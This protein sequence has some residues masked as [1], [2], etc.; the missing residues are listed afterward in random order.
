MG[1]LAMPYEKD[2]VGIAVLNELWGMTLPM[3]G[4][5]YTVKR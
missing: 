4:F 2:T 5:F 1:I 3:S